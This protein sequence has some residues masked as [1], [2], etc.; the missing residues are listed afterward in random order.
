MDT[1]LRNLK[2]LAKNDP[3][4][5][6][7][8]ARALERAL[9]GVET[10]QRRT[11]PSF[12]IFAESAVLEAKN[13]TSYD[14][15]AVSAFRITFPGNFRAAGYIVDIDWA[16]AF[17]DDEWPEIWEGL[18]QEFRDLINTAAENGYQ[19]IFLWNH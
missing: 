16:S 12:K 4:Y 3:S 19:Y 11:T 9:G 5:W 18:S 13:Q 8:Y 1:R 6:P 15:E 14:P 2:R 7:T 17:A 10:F